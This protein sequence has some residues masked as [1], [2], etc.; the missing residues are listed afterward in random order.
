MI[1]ALRQHI[2]RLTCVN[3]TEDSAR[4]CK[5]LVFVYKNN[6]YYILTTDNENLQ[7]L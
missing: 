5:N 7:L 3:K 2:W 4:K 1:G 6:F